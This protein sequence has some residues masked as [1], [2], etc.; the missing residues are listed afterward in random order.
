[1]K[2]M[3]KIIIITIIIITIIGISIFLFFNKKL[4]IITLNIKEVNEK[5]IIGEDDNNTQYKVYIAKPLEIYIAGKKIDIDNTEELSSTILSVEFYTNIFSPN[6]KEIR[7]IKKISIPGTNVIIIAYL[8]DILI[9]DEIKNLKE[10]I[11][12]IDNIVSVEY[13]SKKEMYDEIIESLG[14]DIDNLDES[15]FMNSFVINVN[16]N[17]DFIANEIK[18]MPGVKSINY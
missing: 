4:K 3:T 12:K 14:Y 9:D 18:N 13:K 5:Y 17:A 6:S 10:K 2:N 11:E 1:M 15:R 7:K 16:D 8:D